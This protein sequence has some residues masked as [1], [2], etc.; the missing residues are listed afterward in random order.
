MS[1][2]ADSTICT[3]ELLAALRAVN[4][5]AVDGPAARPTIGAVGAALYQVLAVRADVEATPQTAAWISAL[6][7]WAAAM[8]TWHAAVVG[9][10]TTWNPSSAADIALR[11]AIVNAPGPLAPPPPAPAAPLAE[12]R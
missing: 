2:G 9:A 4:G 3:D 5:D 12:V 11:Q 6:L 10:F 8:D 1:L 7:A